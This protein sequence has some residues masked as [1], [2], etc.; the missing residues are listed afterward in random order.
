MLDVQTTVVHFSGWQMLL[1]A[2]LFLLAVLVPVW[3][4]RRIANAIP[5]VYAPQGMPSGVG[6]LLLLTVG[7]LI[8]EAVNALWHFGRAAGEAARVIA[9][10]SDFVWPAVQTVIPDFAAAFFLMIAV[11]AL[12]F[13]R[14]PFALGLAVFSAW[15]GGPMVAFLRTIYLGLPLEV[16]GEPTGLFFLTLVIT[17]YLLFSNRPALTYGTRAGRQLAAQRGSSRT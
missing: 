11:G 7:I 6:G 1:A 13:G 4:V 9:M 5:P 17:V 10:D 3:A 14:S 8:V 16:A 2:S 12:V 15:L